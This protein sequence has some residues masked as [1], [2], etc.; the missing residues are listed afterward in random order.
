MHGGKNS[1]ITQ[2][3]S[4]STSYAH[5]EKLFL[6]QFYDRVFRG[7]Y[8]ANGFTFLQDF[9]SSITNSMNS[10]QWGMYINY[11]DSQL[12]R[13]AAQEHYW[14]DNLPRLRRI[15]AAL[16]PDDVFYYPQSIQ[17]ALSRNSEPLRH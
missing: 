6:Y 4:A 1:A 11:A 13:M 10:S 8:P 15:K 2:T 16:D 17:P 3:P 12:S 9:T 5:R 14:G 7:P